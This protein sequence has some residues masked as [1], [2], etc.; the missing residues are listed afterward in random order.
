MTNFKDAEK[1]T[2]I[3]Y[4]RIPAIYTWGGQDKKIREEIRRIA[5]ETFQNGLV[6]PF[7]YDW[8]GFQIKVRRNEFQIYNIDLDNVPKLIID[9]FS[10]K[11]I[12]TDSSAY[13]QIKIYADDTMRWVR[14]IQIEVEVTKDTDET[15][16]WIFG[17]NLF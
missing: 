9:S 11:Q 7:D 6:E 12:D 15:D 1:F 13:P 4:F 2:L 3:H 5:S 10:G 17:K 14:A 16:V 8:F